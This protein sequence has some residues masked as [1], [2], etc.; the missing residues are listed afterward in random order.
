MNVIWLWTKA[1]VGP[2]DPAVE[3]FS[4]TKR[5]E[6]SWQKP[7]SPGNLPGRF[8]SGQAARLVALF[9]LI[10]AAAV[11]LYGQQITGSIVGTVKDP[12]GAVVSIA[13]VK[14]T[15]TDTG[16]SRT[17]S[18]N[19]YGE[20]R[21]DDLPVG[22]YTVEAA[23]PGF[24]TYV[25]PNVVLSVDQTQTLNITL[26]VGAQTQTVTVTAAPPLV[27]TS[28]AELGTTIEQ[29]QVVG[30]PL[31]NRNAYAEL[32]LIPGVMANSASQLGNPNGT[33][34]FVIGLPSTDVQINGSIDGGNPEVSFY[35]DGGLNTNGIRNY[36]NQL[37]NPDALQE[38][39]VETSDFSAQYG[40]MSAAV[41]TAVT[42]SGTNEFHGTLFEFNRNTD[43][44]ATNWNASSKAPYHR[45]QFGG[46]I[47]GPVKRDKAFFF[48]SYGG[49]R[50]VV[51]QF[52]SGGVMP[53]A[54]ERLGDFTAD[55]FTVY[56]PGTKT[57][58]DGTNTSP[59]CQTPTPN[60]IPQ[61]LLDKTAASMLNGS[62]KNAYIPL[63]TGAGNT[64]TGFFTGPTSEN[65]YLGKYDEA[66][67]DR[68]HVAVTYFFVKTTQN[69][70]G[71]GNFPWD[72]NQSYT[73][74]TNADVSD[75][76]TFS[77]TTINQTWLTFTRAAGGRVNL[78]TT[79]IGQLG[80]SFTI[81][82]PSALPELSVSGYFSVGGALAGP[83][84]TSD[85]Y[86]IR[87]MVSTTKGKHSLYYG[88]ELALDKGM[89]AANLY[90]FG[91]FSFSSSAPTTTGNALSDFVTG[92]VS[93]MEQDTP[94]HTLMSAWHTAV[95][96]QDNYR[97]TPRF[98]ANLGVRW[99]IDTPPVES[100]NLTDAF[101]PGQQ[102]TV[103]P[104]A[105]LGMVFP[106]D[107]GVAR[108]IVTTKFHHVAPRI[109]FAW[110][111]FGDGKT[112]VRAGAGLFYGTTSGN[113]WNQPG[114]AQ[115]Y[116]IRQTFNSIASLSN[117]YG[118]PASF[119]NGDPF[120]YTYDPK[121]PR[122]LVPA[123]IESIGTNVQWPYIYQFN[124][125]VQ[126]QLPDRVSLTAA[127]VGTLSRDV[128]TM[129]DD[130][131][132]PYAPGATT[133]QASINARRPYDPGVLGQNI[134]LITNQTASYHSLQVSV[135]HPLTRNFMINGF[136]V[137]SHA[138]QS[139]NESAIGQMTA[140][141]F[142]NLWEEKGP[143]DADR[144]SV[145]NI[146]AIWNI[147][148]YHGSNF[149]VKNIVNGW[150]ISPLYSAQSGS[151]FEI[152]TGSTKNDDSNGHNRPDFTGVNPVLDPHR[153]R[154]AVAAEWFNTGANGAPLSFIPNGPG[155][156]GG[157]GPGGADGNTPRD[158]L[159]GPGS[160]DVD[161]G[162]FRDIH[163]AEGITLQL[164][165]EAT[166]AFNL[167][168]L[169]NPSGT[170][171]SGSTFGKITS[172]SSPRI[173]QLGARL[174]F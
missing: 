89:F 117:V 60:C 137:W 79:N 18:T 31:V 106:G 49:L 123:S 67:G 168:S 84:T 93:T 78:P 151:P 85:F 133:S 52:L 155:Q 24:K 36:G 90:N 148:Y 126:R 75:V 47:G 154:A 2:F 35:L 71:N 74:Q 56:M 73:D 6:T 105:P 64:W 125:A 57:Q 38:F 14:A 72:I 46:V 30:L 130:N 3:G 124:L 65:E 160:R 108:G 81:Q 11:A 22:N 102:S 61:S 17:A 104:S 88:G 4:L 45:N 34:N 114:N 101:V 15:N 136:Y 23:A 140:Q 99:D 147:D 110:D 69:A 9:A 143:F 37:P 156:P 134:F 139:S 16:Y 19:E 82:G 121:N 162:I 39:R 142:A 158:F 91:V 42:K 96:L 43:F 83:V 94:Y 107:K 157:I 58:V 1:A 174:T 150:T 144:R 161:L 28:D 128:P 76:H 166:N 21:I 97:V 12:Q 54:N 77:A 171:L 63:P 66:I 165:G 59:N 13:T 32:S 70:F 20:V 48:F 132:A 8:F 7:M 122:F 53:T 145:A 62:N 87:D 98:T 33:P 119:P 173:I 103:V 127:Y 170:T 29:N 131:Y 10:L 44:N 113:E 146:S 153:S 120:P 55:S 92:Q 112:A 163:F 129:I 172:A 40:H 95:F 80:S 152:T 159:R 164:R 141:D 149:F 86:S 169:N 115:P 118:N 109:G 41:V 111:P 167:V 51:G 138:I 25:Q 116:A 135:A 26:E 50:Q 5:R 100:S 27:N 68:D